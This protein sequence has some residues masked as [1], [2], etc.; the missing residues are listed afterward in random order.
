MCVPAHAHA[1]T[2][3]HTHTHTCSKED[4]KMIELGVSPIQSE[5]KV[6]FFPLRII[7]TVR[8]SGKPMR[9]KIYYLEFREKRLKR[10]L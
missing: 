2:H 7:K 1:H 8:K 6:Y 3:T 4:K 10:E 9:V 5:A